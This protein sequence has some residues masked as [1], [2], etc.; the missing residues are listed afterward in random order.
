MEHI[1]IFGII[2]NLVLATWCAVY[3]AQTKKTIEH[4]ILS[5]MLLYSVCYILL[6]F[7]LLV[8]L[9]WTLNL[10][11]EAVPKLLYDL[12][13]MGVCVSEILMVYAMLRIFLSFHGKDLSRGPSIIFWTALFL[14]V[15]SFGLKFLV[16]SGKLKPLLISIHY[17][18][19]DNVIIFEIVILVLLLIRA[20]KISDPRSARLARTFAAMYLS[21]YFLP[22]IISLVILFISP[23]PRPLKMILALAL[24]VYCSFVPILWIRWYLLDSASSGAR[25]IG[26]GLSL[27]SIVEEHGISHRERE[28]LGLLLMGKSHREI[29]EELFISYHTVKNH[30]YNLYQKLGVKNRHQLFHLFTRSGRAGGG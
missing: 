15:G 1:G 25:E 22:I 28:I 29:E 5:P 16:S 3:I 19:F 18:V 21:R 14:F 13:L 11:A 23:L 27:D 24:F 7:F 26:D 8:Y 9:Y 12:G 17:F 6:V 2:V 10:S 30:I 4:R 20:R